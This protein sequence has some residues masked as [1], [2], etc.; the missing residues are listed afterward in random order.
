MAMNT[1]EPV[2]VPQADIREEL[3]LQLQA[4]FYNHL[5]PDTTLTPLQRVPLSSR[6][7]GC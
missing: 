2:T 4:L 3:L 1:P 6:L 5:Q 7:M